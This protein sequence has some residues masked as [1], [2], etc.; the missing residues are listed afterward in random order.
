[1]TRVVVDAAYVRWS[2]IEEARV[3]A[4][5]RGIDLDDR[6]GKD[7]IAFHNQAYFA[8]MDVVRLFLRRDILARQDDESAAQA[9]ART[10][11]A[12]LRNLRVSLQNGPIH[13]CSKAQ[14]DL[15]MG[16]MTCPENDWAFDRYAGSQDALF[17]DLHAVRIVQTQCRYPLSGSVVPLACGQ[18][19]DVV[20]CIRFCTDVN[21]GVAAGK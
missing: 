6:L 2:V 15:G 11:P 13:L 1:M 21:A 7:H 16:V 14:K 8:E 10:D 12:S 9:H 4:G 19:R 5:K 18:D 17:A 3:L 20:L